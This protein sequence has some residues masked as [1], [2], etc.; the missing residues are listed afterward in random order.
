MTEHHARPG[1][2]ARPLISII[3]SACNAEGFVQTAMQSM[4]GQTE[5]DFEFLIADDA[6][7]DRTADQI[8]A[9]QDPRI[10]LHKNPERLGLTATLNNLLPLARGEFIARM[11]ADDISLPGRLAAQ[12]ALLR[13]HKDIWVCGGAFSVR[14]AE[15][16]YLDTP[17]QTDGEI[18]AA[19]LFFNP[20]PH[21]FVMFRGATL[22]RHN[23]RYDPK[24]TCA[25]DYELWMRLALHHPE[26]RFANLKDVL[27]QYHRHSAQVS[28]RRTQEQQALSKRVQMQAFR[29]LGFSPL[30]REIAFHEHFFFASPIKTRAEIAG[31]F[32]W[33]LRLR[34]ANDEKGIFDRTHF[35]GFLRQRLLGLAAS[36]PALRQDGTRLLA[37]WPE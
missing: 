20:L 21:P 1:K 2:S 8:A 5:G 30:C 14:S 19:L 10:A 4:L 13:E 7:D 26:A 36:N 18:K 24:M 34:H 22:R 27:G 15:H 9:I 29:L 3:M 33:A 37:A 6:S 11:D 35:N 25:Q 28:S 31:A 17:P 23:L 12:A 16:C 32:D